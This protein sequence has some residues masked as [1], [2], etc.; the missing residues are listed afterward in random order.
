MKLPGKGLIIKVGL[1]LAIIGGVWGL[2]NLNSI[3]GTDKV[4]LNDP[5]PIIVMD[6]VALNDP[7]P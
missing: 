1:G 7:N 6:K 2:N 3:I 5:N 4:A